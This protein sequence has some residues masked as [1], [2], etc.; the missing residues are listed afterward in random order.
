MLFIPSQHLRILSSA[1]AEVTLNT[2]WSGVVV[3]VVQPETKAAV[4]AAVVVF[5]KT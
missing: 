4:A 5:F 2:S 3:L 1:L